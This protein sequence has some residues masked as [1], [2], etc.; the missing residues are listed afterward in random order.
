[1]LF[2]VL[3]G[4]LGAKGRDEALL[5]GGTAAAQRA[6]SCMAPECERVNAYFEL[7]LLGKPSLDVHCAVHDTTRHAPAP[8]GCDSAWAAVLSWFADMAD[9]VRQSDV[10]IMAEVDAD[11]GPSVRPG[12]YLIQRERSDLVAPFLAAVGESPKLAAWDAVRARLPQGWE[13]TYVGL[14]P[15]RPD[16]LL[17]V[18]AHPAVVDFTSLDEACDQLGLEVSDNSLAL[19]QDLLKMG[20][21]GF[22]L[23]LDIDDAGVI[24]RDFGLEVYLEGEKKTASVQKDEAARG[25]FRLLEASGAADGRWRLLEG[26]DVSKQVALPYDRAMANASVSL[27]LFSVKVKFASGMPRLA[28]AYL[29]G[30]ALLVR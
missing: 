24:Q 2:A 11:T 12:M 30:D 4:M 9:D 15:S 17:R 7:P 19:I 14:F 28:K 1:M 16:A 18:N 23:Q 5:G 6:W 10:Q 13:A 21:R 3:C 27:R 22:D 29:R 20:G 26:V 25:L 8:A